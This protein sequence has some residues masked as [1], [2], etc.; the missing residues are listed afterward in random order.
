M[1]QYDGSIRIDTEIQ[2]KQAQKELKSLESSMDKTADK[3]ASLRSK[4]DALKDVKLPT[5][6]YKEISAQIEKAEQRFDKL[7]E[8]QKQMQRDGKDSGAAWQ[9][10][11]DQIADTDKEIALARG[12]LQDLVDTGKAFT[13]GSDTEEYSKLGQELQYAEN[14]L[15]A[16]NKRHDELVTKQET[17][18]ERFS[19]MR[20]SAK[21]AFDALVSGFKNVGS[22]ASKFIGKMAVTPF[23]LLAST[24]KKAFSAISSGSRQSSGFL[25]GFTSQLKNIV[26]AAFV[27]NLIRKGFNSLVSSMKTGF[28]N[29][30][31]YSRSFAN[32]IQSVKNSLS[33][34]GN[35]MAA[36]FAPIVQAIIPWLN[37]LI[38]VLAI[39]ISYVSQFIA[40]LTGKGTYIRAKK[41]QDSYGASLGGTA[42]KEE[43]AADNAD[44]MSDALDDSAKSA[45]KARGALAAFDDLDVLEKQDDSTDAVADKIK[46]LNKELGNLGGDGVGDLFEE[47]PIE[48][49]IL[50]LLDWLKEM[51]ENSDFYELG[52]ILGEKLKEALDSIPWD[53]IKEIARKIGKSLATLINGF[54]EVEGLGASIGRTLA[55]ALNSAFEFLNAFVHELHWDSIGEFISETINGFFQNIDWDL[56]YNTLV[57]AAKGFG[58]AINAFVDNLDWEEIATAI[59]NFVNTIVDTIYKFITTTD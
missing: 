7:L 1:P 55:E 5:Q 19:K 36:A 51:W 20:D 40:A 9:R 31:I 50:D 11:N 44:D 38:S 15:S 8:K 21:K 34:L 13:F 18:S 3:I 52:K 43:E 42:K 26:S 53:E 47:V 32:S 16:L 28:S 17:I 25:S 6:E 30:M 58:D 59:S 39:A 54:I 14:N 10:L 27:F 45:K 33:T 23:S 46:D 37:Q 48:N 12:E 24:A 35:Q 56:I 57:T 29:L 2:T 49:S 22:A 4:M 41:V